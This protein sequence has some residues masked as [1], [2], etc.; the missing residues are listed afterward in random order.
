MLLMLI[1]RLREYIFSI[2]IL[3]LFS[4]IILN[5][6]KHHIAILIQLFVQLILKL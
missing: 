4:N 1:M 3:L 2:I 5:L 6:K